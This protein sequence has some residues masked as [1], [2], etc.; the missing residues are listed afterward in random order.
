MFTKEELMEVLSFSCSSWEG[1]LRDL[2]YP[3]NETVF[4]RN[5]YYVTIVYFKDLFI[6]FCIG[7]CLSLCVY[8]HPGAYLMHTE[9]IYFPGTGVTIVSCHVGAVN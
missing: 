4:N 9:A 1:A 8:V 2:Y 6:S 3:K 5:M 7:I